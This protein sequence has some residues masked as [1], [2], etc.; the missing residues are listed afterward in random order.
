MSAT[1]LQ[2]GVWYRCVCYLSLKP[3]WRLGLKFIVTL[4]ALKVQITGLP[5]FVSP[6]LGSSYYTVLQRLSSSLSFSSC[7]FNLALVGMLV[8]SGQGS[9]YVF[10][11]FLKPQS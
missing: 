3:V 11:A 1:S 5:T 7:Y 8:E 2:L 4:S 6:G 9:V 10:D